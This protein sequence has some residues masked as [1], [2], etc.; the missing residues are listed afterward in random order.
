M[1]GAS[2]FLIKALWKVGGRKVVEK[3]VQKSLGKAIPVLGAAIGG[4]IDWF[5][6]QAVGKLA[7]PPSFSAR[8]MD[9][10]IQF[11]LSNRT[12]F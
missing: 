1:K 11:C 3:A 10:D 6:T 12:N 9:K 8:R 7:S 2:K 5:S 4:S